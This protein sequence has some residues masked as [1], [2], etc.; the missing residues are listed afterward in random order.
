VQLELPEKICFSMSEEHSHFLS[1]LEDAR[2]PIAITH[3]R[4]D[5]ISEALVDNLVHG[6]L[7]VS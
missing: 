7:F 3:F 1:S 6:G 4:E 5:E 2:C